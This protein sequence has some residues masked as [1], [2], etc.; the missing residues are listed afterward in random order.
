MLTILI[1]LG[2]GSSLASIWASQL[3]VSL[4]NST[5]LRPPSGWSH[6]ARRGDSSCE[7]G[8]CRLD[9]AHLPI[10]GLLGALSAR[11]PLQLPLRLCVCLSGSVRCCQILHRLPCL[12]SGWGDSF[13]RLAHQDRLAYLDGLAANV[14]LADLKDSKTLYR[15]V[16][17][18]FPASRSGRR[19]TF[20]PLPTVL[21]KEGQHSQWGGCQTGTM[22]RAFR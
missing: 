12:C 6:G 2:N 15:R 11:A 4:G 13:K 14:S 16:R 22:A 10:A 9:A 7:L 19:P 17:Q 8:A 21:D 18:A 5:F 3:F 20:C 1:R